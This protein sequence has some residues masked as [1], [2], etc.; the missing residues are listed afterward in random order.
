M[1]REVKLSKYTKLTLAPASHLEYIV[2][3][4]NDDARH[5]LGIATVITRPQLLAI[6]LMVDEVLDESKES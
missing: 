5:P 1:K 3:T 4:Y 2:G 6:K